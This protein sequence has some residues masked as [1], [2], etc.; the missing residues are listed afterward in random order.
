MLADRLKDIEN[1]IRAACTRAGRQ[2]G[3]VEI[4]AVTKTIPPEDINEAID[5]GLR[6]IGENRVQE[7]LKKRGD[8]HEHEFHLVGHLQRNKVKSILKYCAMIHS[9]DSVRLAEE[10]DANA[11]SLGLR[12]EILIEVNTSG[13]ESKEGVLPGELIPLARRIAELENL[14]LRG[15]MT[16]ASLKEDPEEVRPE[17]RILRSLRDGMREA[18][19]SLDASHLSMGMTNDFEQAIEEG[20]TLIRLGTALFGH[21]SN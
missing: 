18:L 10:I 20:A 4:V 15:L 12:P 16:V 6:K 13:E 3:V 1:R 8:L 21:R 2:R 5:A 19:P 9:V 17:F 11:A 14:R 7:Y